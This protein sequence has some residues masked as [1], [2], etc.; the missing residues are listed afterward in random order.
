MEWEVGVS[1][2]KLLNI[3]WKNN[4]ALLCSAENCIQDPMINRKEQ[5]F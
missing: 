1:R 4:K 2:C 3:E 5:D